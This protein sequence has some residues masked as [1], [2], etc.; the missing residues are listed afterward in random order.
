MEQRGVEPSRWARLR[1][2][3]AASALQAVIPHAIAKADELAYRG[4]VASEAVTGHGYGQDFWYKSNEQLIEYTRGIPGIRIR[5]L[6]GVRRYFDCVVVEE[7]SIAI[8]PVRLKAS[9][10]D[11]STVRLQNPPSSSLAF[12]LGPQV[13]PA[14]PSTLDDELFGVA[15]AAAQS[16]DDAELDEQIAQLGGVVTLGIEC[17]HRTG[18]SRLT[19]GDL[20]LVDGARQEAVWKHPENLSALRRGEEF[21]DVAEMPV[22]VGF[23]GASAS[24]SQRFDSTSDDDDIALSLRRPSPQD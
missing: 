3:E 5:S 22:A 16:D 1:C 21:N 24:A 18:V 13:Q 8:V 19:W 9:Q 4:H 2:G 17:N 20:F 23:G 11:R 14:Q 6:E 10:G 7:T 15:Q 12:L